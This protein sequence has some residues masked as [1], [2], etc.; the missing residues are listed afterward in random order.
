MY[1]GIQNT[2]GKRQIRK[3][4]DLCM[5]IHFQSKAEIKEEP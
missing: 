3:R 1:Q 5:V 4:H 2:E